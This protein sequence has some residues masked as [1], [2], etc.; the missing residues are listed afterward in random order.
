MELADTLRSGRSAARHDGS[1]PSRGTSFGYEIF[2][3]EVQLLAL[4]RE[5]CFKVEEQALL[6]N[7][8]HENV[9]LLKGAR[10]T[11]LGLPAVFTPRLL[12]H[13]WRNW[14]TRWT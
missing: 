2:V 5:G 7:L 1:T 3:K 6:L 11:G 8:P 9:R 12:S 4:G 13:L 10:G 14:Q